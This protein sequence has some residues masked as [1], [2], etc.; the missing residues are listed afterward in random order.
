MLRTKY[1]HASSRF[2]SAALFALG[3]APLGA[4]TAEQ[5]L[6]MGAVVEMR[7]VQATGPQGSPVRGKVDPAFTAAVGSYARQVMGL[8]ELGGATAD[9]EIRRAL[10]RLA[11]AIEL[12]PGA[13]RAEVASAAQQIRADASL[14]MFGLRL[15]PEGVRPVAHAMEVSASALGQLAE[16][17]YRA[18]RPVQDRSEAFRGAVARLRVAGSDLR[19][20]RDQVVA[21]LQHAALVLTAMHTAAARGELF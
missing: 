7:P 4:C 13:G 8:G 2:A 6:A 10:E 14:M 21:A 11:D 1:P 15:G 18:A 16:G 9:A 12:T 5:E 19:P 3:S 20:P 17:P